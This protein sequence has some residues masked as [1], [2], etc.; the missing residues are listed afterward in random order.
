MIYQST[1]VSSLS[2]SCAFQFYVS[3]AESITQA[4]L[5]PLEHA[6]AEVPS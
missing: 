3:S 4:N 2:K 6:V 5:G 1:T